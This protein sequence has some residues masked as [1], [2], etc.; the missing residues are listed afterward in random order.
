MRLLLAVQQQATKRG[1]QFR[2]IKV[3]AAEA[4]EIAWKLCER[5]Y[6][7]RL[8]RKTPRADWPNLVKSSKFRFDRSKW[9]GKTPDFPDQLHGA[10]ASY[11][12]GWN[13]V[14]SYM[15]TLRKH[16]HPVA[17]IDGSFC[18]EP[19]QVCHVGPPQSRDPTFRPAYSCCL[20]PFAHRVHSPWK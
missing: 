10:K 12:V 8:K 1:H 14:P 6:Y 18:K 11:I 17:A 15:K 16:M 7:V 3:G 20:C 4:N 5:A 19:A 9:Q 13:I 2:I